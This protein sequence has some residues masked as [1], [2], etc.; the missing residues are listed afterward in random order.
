MLQGLTEFLPV[1][2]S[3]H[4][5]LFQRILG[6]KGDL[7]LFDIV[8]HLGTLFAVVFIFRKELWECI[9]HP[10]SRTSLSL[11]AAT[12]PAVLLAVFFRDF[13]E[14][15]FS[16]AYL[17]F[18][19]LVTAAILFATGFRLPT[20][21]NPALCRSEKNGCPKKSSSADIKDLKDPVGLG[22][23]WTKALT[24]G[25]FQGAALLPGISRSGAT[26]SGG[27]ICGMEREKAARFSFLLCVPIILA[28]AVY[29][30][31]G[32][33]VSAESADALPALIGFIAAAVSGFLAIKFMLDMI[34]KS[35]LWYFA[36]YLVVLGVFVLLNQYV[37]KLF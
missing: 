26:V 22:V 14:K 3:G 4:L 28:S 21:P 9:K 17:G 25:L 30:I 2:S 27:L 34:K 19:F 35:K 15:T 23:S 11:A 33:A 8:L 32:A 5:V 37:L 12:A 18:G 36:V 13:I 20:R 29:K 16:G 10:L 7:L 1:S 31:A 24:I 6:M